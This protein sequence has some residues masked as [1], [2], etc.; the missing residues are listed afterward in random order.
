MTSDEALML[1]FQSGSRAAFEELFGRYRKVLY[2][3]F[4]RRLN[5]PER[6]EDLTQETFLAVIRAAS[7]YEPR[8]SVRTY[9]YGIAL[10][11]LAAERRKFLTGSTC[12]QSAPE[13]KTDGTPDC[14]LWVRQAMEKLDAPDREILMLRE[15]EQLSY[16]DIAAL[17]RIPVNTVRSRLFRSRLALKSYLE[18]EV[19]TDPA[20]RASAGQPHPERRGMQ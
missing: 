5:N 19:K 1:E 8:A 4:G 15:Y 20:P 14:V 12:G 13:P 16:S 9:L 7:R 6:A 3:F 17:L 10:K 11:L 2:G 18:S